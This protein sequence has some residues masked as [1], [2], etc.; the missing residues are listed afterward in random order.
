MRSAAE[1]DHRRLPRFAQSE[2]SAEVSICRDYDP[3]V[4]LGAIENPRVVGRLH[5][6]VAH[7]RR[8]MS[9]VAQ[10]FGHQWR[11]RIIDQKSQQA[12]RSGNSRSRT[13]SAA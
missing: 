8:V 4:A 10:A 7:V 3:A 9:G 12:E 2:K 11:E 13:A 1:E 5:P 6:V